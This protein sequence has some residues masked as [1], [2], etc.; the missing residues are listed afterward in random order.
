MSR[1]LSFGRKLLRFIFSLLALS[2]V[3]FYAARLAPGDPLV[4]YY[5]D[6]AER[7]TAEERARAEQRLGLQAPLHVQYV[8]WL[9]NVLHG[10]FGLSL[11]YKMPVTEV[12]R[13]RMGNSLVLG[14]TGFLPIFALAPLLGLLCA[15]REDGPLDRLLRAAG[16]LTSCVPEF[17]GSLLLILVFS[18]TLRWLPSG[19]AYTPGDGGGWDR[20]S[21]LIL[22][23]AA[24]VSGHLWYYACLVRN[25]LLEEIRFDY[26]LL[27]RA[28]GLSRGQ[29]L[30]RHCLRGI[31]PSYLSLMAV[32]VPH[33]LG[34]AYVVEAVFAYPGLGTLAYESAR[35]QDYHLLMLLCLLSGAVV[36][37]CSMAA[38]SFSRR[39]DPRFRD[40]EGP[41]GERGEFHG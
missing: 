24:V 28:K 8:R 37:L 33:I 9:E 17:Y 36:I 20:F 39:V 38:Q 12:V 35:Y 30:V 3:V 22:P 21:H 26:V 11:K 2:L 32:S 31:L 29:V 27:A 14:G 40:L 18:V 10:D 13:S 15:W 16:N 7:L 6:R 25:R 19:G 4:S 1:C 5:G 34:G 41:E 23:L